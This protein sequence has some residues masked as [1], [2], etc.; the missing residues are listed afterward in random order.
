MKK[1]SDAT[2]HIQH[3][4]KRY[5]RKVIHFDRLQFVSGLP[6]NISKQFRAT[7]EVSNVDAVMEQAKLLITMEE[8]QKVAAT[9]IK[10]TEVQ[11]LK[12][13]IFLLTEHCLL[14]L[15]NDQQV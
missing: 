14:N 4:L 5:Q 10:S 9:C 6:A 3:T 13:Q 12:E 8:P 11:E 1:L 2:Y 15:Q 7:G